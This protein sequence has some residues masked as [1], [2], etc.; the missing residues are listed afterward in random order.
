[1]AFTTVPGANGAAD[2]FLGT[3]GV[4]I[5]TLNAIARPVFLGARQAN[6]SVSFNSDNAG[7]LNAYTLNG[8]DGA[9]T[10]TSLSSTNLNRSRV[11]GD[12]GDD[13]FILTGLISSTASG[14]QGSDV[15]STAGLVTSSL[16]NGNQGNDTLNINA[17][18]ATSS[19]FAGIG[20]D[21]I[22]LTTT[23]TSSVAQANEGTD[24]I[25]IAAGTSISGS[26]VNGND[27][28]DTI[29]VNAI[30]AFTTSTIFGGA[31]NDTIN[32][33]VS[34]VGIVAQGDD[35]ADSVTGGAGAD[36]IA[37]G[38][39]NDTI[40]GG[41]GADS[42]T[43]NAGNNRFV[44]SGAVGSADINNTIT[45]F[46]L[47]GTNNVIDF[48]TNAAGGTNINAG[49]FAAR[50]INANA[51]V[52]DGFTFVTSTNGTVAASLRTT[53]VAAFLG[54]INGLNSARIQWNAPDNI[55]YIAV[56]DGT[57]LG[58]FLAD[59]DG[60]APAIIASELTLIARL[61][62]TTTIAAANLTDFI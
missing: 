7:A 43:G 32:A 61:D 48:I 31:G 35:G 30:A 17:G 15:V 51:N 2:S 50:A 6:D 22:A 20:D 16:I 5:I 13:A 1:M 4:D 49:S 60:I 34:N 9:D 47:T 56:T 59:D 28:N 38:D 37:G 8:G 3:S 39:G 40:T 12:A 29:T 46:R 33:A 45:D 44:F 52:Q 25:T 23:L 55:A 14:G 18:A 10:F 57:N 26:T 58:I 62:N 19:I 27:G 42:L 41:N 54:N 53:D 21:T 11:L 24:T 36:T